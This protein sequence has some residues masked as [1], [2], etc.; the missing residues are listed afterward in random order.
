MRLAGTV[1]LAVLATTCSSPTK[2]GPVTPDLVIQSV[3]PT[4]G[5]AS[6]GTEV[7]IR[8]AGFATGATISIGGR[9]ATDVAV[10]GADVIAAKTPVSTIAGP[11]D[12]VVSLNGRTN[13]LAGGFRYEVTGPNT[14]PVIRSFTAQG[15]RLRQP[16][17]F[18]DYG[19]SIQLTLVVEDAES[20]PAQLNYQWRPCD[21]TITGTGPQ[22][23]WTAP[24]LGTLPST[25]TI[26][27]TI[28][29][30]P[31]V[32][33]RSVVVRLHNSVEEVKSLVLEFLTEFANSMIP[34]ETTVRNFSSACPGKAAEL[35]DVMNNR[36]TRTINSHTY[37]IPA[38]TVAFSA[39]CRST[40]SDAC[41]RTAVEWQSTVIATN[42]PETAKGTSVISAVYTG[43][44]WWLCDSAFD[45]ASSLGLHF[46]H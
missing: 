42:L 46:M 5:P 36:A 3:T 4:A 18:A 24:A 21:G 28:T 12:V 19:E 23:D 37:G 11:V 13:A 20:T 45:G 39:A 33:T 41:V 30:G 35:K 43:S 34:A 40:T 14:A 15:R 32:A 10:R 25:C 27:V 8:G 2:P 17:S 29:D 44:R 26:E 7:T 22:V 9:P 38:V 6:G 1:A 16:A 31:H